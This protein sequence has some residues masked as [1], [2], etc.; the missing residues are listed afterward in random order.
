VGSSID[1][2]SVIS[3]QLL[4]YPR[5]ERYPPSAHRVDQALSNHVLGSAVSSI[6]IDWTWADGTGEVRDRYDD[7]VESPSGT[8]LFGLEHNAPAEQPWFGLPDPQIFL[9]SGDVQPDRVRAVGMY[10][11]DDFQSAM[12]YVP[13]TTVFPVNIETVGDLGPQGFDEVMFY[14]AI[15]GFNQDEPLDVAT[16]EPDPEVGYTPWPTAIR[17]TLTVHDPSM[18]LEN[19]RE[20]QFIIDLP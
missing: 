9:G 12:D 1:Q 17:V 16:G 10:G 4:F 2:Y 13:A 6:R 15:F 3:S 11:D 14:E 18:T 19:G 8:V 5:A 7:I 20:V